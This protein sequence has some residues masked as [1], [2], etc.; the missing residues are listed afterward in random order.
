MKVLVLN[1]PTF[2]LRFSRDGR[3]QSEENTWLDTFPPTAFASIAGCVREKYELKLID[4]MGSKLSFED[5]MKIVN[6]FSPDFS[7]INT[8]TPTIEMDVNT[9]DE[10]KKLTGSKIIMY[11]EHVTSRYKDLLEKHKQIDFAVLGEAETPVMSILE[12]KYKVK[13]V[14]TRAWDGGIWQEPDLDSLPFPAYDLLPEYRFPLTGEKW[15]FARSGR[16]CPFNCSYCVMPLLA[17]RNVR[18]HSAEYMVEQFKWLVNDIGI[19][20]WMMWDELATFDRERMKKFCDLMV[21]EGLSKKVKWFCTTRVDC[22]D[23]ELAKKMKESGCQM[24]SFGFESGNQNVLNRN[25]KGITIEQSKKAAKTARDNGLKIIGHFIIGLPGSDEKTEM[26]TIN[27]AKE[28]KINFAQFYIA[29][30]FPG[31]KFYEDAK[32]NGWFSSDDWKSVEQGTATVSYPN[33]SSNQIQ[34]YRRKAYRSFYMR[35]FAVK[36]VL[37]MMSAKQLIRLPLFVFNFSKWMK[38]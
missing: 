25:N 6:N 26:D 12:G 27:F 30:P 22:F 5:C 2:G 20:V 9:A 32:K 33:F 19:K 34:L 21:K 37:S 15:T 13:G 28:L 18:Y 29:T 31:S 3:C 35:L 7:I 14:A 1:P 36:S 17:G 10:I 11:G 38:K 16:G 8:S 4:C 23:D 24:I